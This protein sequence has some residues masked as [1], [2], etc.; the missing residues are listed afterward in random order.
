MI[1][2]IKQHS[3]YECL[4]ILSQKNYAHN[5][6]I[7]AYCQA[8]LTHEP[9]SLLEVYTQDN[10]ARFRE[11]PMPRNHNGV[12]DIQLATS[13]EQIELQRTSAAIQ[14]ATKSYSHHTNAT[15]AIIEIGK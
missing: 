3:Y 1:N 2:K 8:N 13:L 15:I 10:K 12:V 5:H 6:N 7:N 4:K 9:P 14:M 11:I